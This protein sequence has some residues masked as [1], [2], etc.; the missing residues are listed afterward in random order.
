MDMNAISVGSVLRTG[1]ARNG[2]A[3]TLKSAY[4]AAGWA[5]EAATQGRNPSTRNRHAKEQSRL[6]LNAESFRVGLEEI[7]LVLLVVA[8]IIGVAYGFTCL[9]DLVQNWAIFERG[10]ANLI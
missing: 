8:A 3:T 2:A 5:R 4:S 9:I 1:G 7:F 6:G 10:T